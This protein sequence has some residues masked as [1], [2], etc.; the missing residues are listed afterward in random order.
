MSGRPVVVR[1]PIDRWRGDGSPTCRS[2]AQSAFARLKICPSLLLP[3][4]LRS[5]NRACEPA[6]ALPCTSV[7]FLRGKRK[8]PA[9][10]RGFWT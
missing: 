10:N 7:Q 4:L 8:G 9:G 6:Y 2:W 1:Q 5:R 3:V